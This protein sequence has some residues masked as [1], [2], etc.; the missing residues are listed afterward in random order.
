[1]PHKSHWQVIVGILILFST[2]AHADWGVGA[3]IGTTGLG[4]DLTHHASSMLTLRLGVNAL[5]FQYDAAQS[6]IHYNITV[7]LLSAAL[8]MDWRPQTNHWQLSAGILLNNN[9]IRFHSTNT[10][11]SF[12]IGQVI[13][14]LTNAKITG[15]IHFSRFAPY[16]GIGWHTTNRQKGTLLLDVGILFQGVPKVDLRATGRM[17]LLDI[18]AVPGF[19]QNLEREENNLANEQ[20]NLQY[21]PVIALGW[22]F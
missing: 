17:G 7:Q 21:F 8:L 11:G 9:Q 2:R 20:Q 14:S 18:N 1:M 10:K 12:S 4:L 6:E 15:D 16:I 19:A 13:Y 3:R 22:Y 5:D